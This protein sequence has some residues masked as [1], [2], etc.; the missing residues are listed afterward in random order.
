MHFNG[1]N[2]PNRN[3]VEKVNDP[4]QKV[5]SD[6]VEYNYDVDCHTVGMMQWSC[7]KGEVT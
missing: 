3:S 1:W 2:L 4:V 5:P 6:K 7:K